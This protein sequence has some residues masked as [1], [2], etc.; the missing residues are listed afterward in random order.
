MWDRLSSEILLSHRGKMIGALLGLLLALMIMRFGLL[1]TAFIVLC[2]F[3][4]YHIGK[5]FD[6]NKEGIIEIVER[7]L[8]PG[9]R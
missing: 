3:V 8:P 9:D 6:E 4:G 5:R 1:W 7:Y 2:T